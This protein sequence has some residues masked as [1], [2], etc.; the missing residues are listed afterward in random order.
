M[1]GKEPEITEASSVK[2]PVSAARAEGGSTRAAEM[3][4]T[5][6]RKVCHDTE[7]GID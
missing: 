7:L 1:T 2:G 6:R 5:L 4:R 3:C